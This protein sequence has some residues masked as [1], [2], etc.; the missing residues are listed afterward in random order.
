M[1]KEVITVSH[2]KIKSEVTT[3]Y[4]LTNLTTQVPVKRSRQSKISFATSK[5]DSEKN[6]KIVKSKYDGLLSTLSSFTS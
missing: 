1:E 4:G 2:E 3:A 6:L 5:R